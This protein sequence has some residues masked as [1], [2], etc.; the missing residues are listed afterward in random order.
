MRGPLQP[1]S[2]ESSTAGTK[3]APAA[4]SAGQL[5]DRAAP[6]PLQAARP[7]AVA[8]AGGMRRRPRAAEDSSDDTRQAAASEAP[9]SAVFLPPKSISEIRRV[10]RLFFFV[11][12]AS[13]E[14]TG[15]LSRPWLEPH[16]AEF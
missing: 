13:E 15:F 7:G 8:S 9:G 12:Q 10:R 16:D 4:S 6:K 3:A 2:Q 14:S 5:H 11:S 1:H